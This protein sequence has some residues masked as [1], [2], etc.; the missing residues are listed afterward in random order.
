VLLLLRSPPSGSPAAVASIGFGLTAAGSASTA[1]LSFSLGLTL[2]A[3]EINVSADVGF[4]NQL[5]GISAGFLSAPATL[6]PVAI[7]VS[8]S[9][10]FGSVTTLT[11]L[12]GLTGTVGSTLQ[13]QANS[14]M[15]FGLSGSPIIVSPATVGLNLGLT[16]AATLSGGTLTPT[17]QVGIR[18]DLTAASFLG[19]QAICDTQFGLQGTGFP[20]I[21][22][23]A[24][25][26]RLSFSSD[27][28]RTFFR[29]G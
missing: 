1:T 15:T 20:Q 28:I 27:E 17:A 11:T 21:V 4:T 25:Q 29:K 18:L 7:N 23:L 3:I 8:A 22:G 14:A 5:T 16:A 19:S 13:G 26:M 2:S 24:T 10:G 9:G 12:F 6:I